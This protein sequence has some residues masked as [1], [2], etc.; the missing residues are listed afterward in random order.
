MKLARQAGIYQ[1]EYRK[2]DAL[3]GRNEIPHIADELAGIVTPQERRGNVHHKVHHVVLPPPRVRSSHGAGSEAV[4]EQRVHDV[5]KR[6]A[7]RIH[8]I[9]KVIVDVVVAIDH[10]AQPDAIQDLADVDTVRIA[11]EGVHVGRQDVET[12][13]CH[14]KRRHVEEHRSFRELAAR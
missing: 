10:S 14:L 4:V 8:L 7:S 5:L 6:T 1:G 3:A 11:E 12:F 13:Q 2:N 9:R